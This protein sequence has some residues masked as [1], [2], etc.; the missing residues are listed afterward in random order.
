MIRHN[1]L[2]VYYLTPFQRICNSLVPSMGIC[3][4]LSMA[5][6]L[7]AT[8]SF[9]AANISIFP[10]KQGRIVFFALKMLIL[11]APELQIRENGERGKIDTLIA[12]TTTFQRYR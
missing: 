8:R 11:T 9:S 4:S 7:M 5:V 10:E 2:L 1:I 6:V 3:N 12:I